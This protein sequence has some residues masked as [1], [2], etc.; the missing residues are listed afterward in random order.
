MSM[1]SVCKL[2][3]L[4]SFA[5]SVSLAKS[6]PADPG[7][8]FYEQG[9]FDKAAQ[10]WSGPANEGD[11]VALHNMGML[12]RYGLG[13]TALD[14]NKA[15]VWFLRSA[16]QQYVPAMI[17]LSEVQSELGQDT[18]AQSWLALAARWGNTEAI[19]QLKTK[20]LAVPEADLYDAMMG[21][22]S[23]EDMRATGDLLRPPI[24]EIRSERVEDDG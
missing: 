12:S 21:Q 8:D 6:P 1:N 13:S 7:A 10:A 24:R 17:S 4:L 23:L 9:E 22:K 14:L 2:C 19:D 11:V 18:P 5:A 16:Q 15:A 3:L 20:G